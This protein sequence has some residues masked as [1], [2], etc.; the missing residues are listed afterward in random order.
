MPTTIGIVVSSNGPFP[1]CPTRNNGG[2]GKDKGEGKGK[3]KNNDSGGSGN[4][5]RGSNTPVWPSFYNPCT[6]TNSMW[7]GMRPP[8]QSAQPP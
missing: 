6:G 7:P 2:K 8:Q 1:S 4:N 5:S 3:A